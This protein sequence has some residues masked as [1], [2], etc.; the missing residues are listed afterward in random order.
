MIQ[1]QREETISHG[2]NQMSGVLALGIKFG[3]SVPEMW[4]SDSCQTVFGP[5]KRLHSLRWS[6]EENALGQIGRIRLYYRD[7]WSVPRAVHHR[8]SN[9]LLWPSRHVSVRWLLGV[10]EMRFKVSS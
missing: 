10:P 1:V 9:R 8:H 7:R 4:P 3:F 5:A 2:V 6:S